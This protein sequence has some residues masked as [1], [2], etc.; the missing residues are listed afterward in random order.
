MRASK[1]L[2]VVG[3][4]LILGVLTVVS[5]ASAFPME[6]SKLAAGQQFQQ[7][8]DWFFHNINN[9]AGTEGAIADGPLQVS[10]EVYLQFPAPSDGGCGFSYPKN[11]NS[12]DLGVRWVLQRAAPNSTNFNKCEERQGWFTNSGYKTSYMQIFRQWGDQT[13]CGEGQY[14]VRSY[15]RYR[16]SDNVWHSGGVTTR[17]IYQQ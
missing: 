13:P 11:A 14:R 7:A 17:S 3:A 8:S 10:A 4:L 5:P 16:T 15:G 9:C 12:G 2:F 6:H 1:R